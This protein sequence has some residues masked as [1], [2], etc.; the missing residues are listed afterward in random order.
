MTV[1]TSSVAGLY[2]FGLIV[3]FPV[4]ESMLT[5]ESRA[6]EKSIGKS[7][8]NSLFMG[9][10]VLLGKGIMKIEKTGIETEMGKIGKSLSEIEEEKTPLQNKLE[11]FTKQLAQIIM[12]V[13]F[14]VFVMNL[15]IL[16]FF[17]CTFL[18]NNFF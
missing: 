11:V 6:V 7:G 4:D 1:L 15:K 2:S 8:N 12:V 18:P 17:S 14:L 5:G 13:C 3:N 16:F 10:T 9:T